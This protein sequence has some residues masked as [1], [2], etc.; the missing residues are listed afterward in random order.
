LITSAL[1]IGPPEEGEAVPI[2]RIPADH[3]FQLVDRRTDIPSRA[4]N[5]ELGIQISS[6]YT[7][8][9][10]PPATTDKQKSKQQTANS[11]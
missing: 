11:R 4:P 5:L 9:P 3:I 1:I 8:P 6:P 2:E 7:D 10:R